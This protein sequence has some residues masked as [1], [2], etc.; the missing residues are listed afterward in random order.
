MALIQIHTTPLGPGLPNLVTLLF[1]RQV[2]G[3]MPV[4]DCKPI[5]QDHDG[6]HYG[7]LMDRQHTNDND[8]PPVFS[9]IP[10]GSAVVIQQEDGRL[11]THGMVVNKGN[12]NYHS[13]LYTI[14]L[15]TNGR[16][17]TQNR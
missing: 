2:Q 9:Y 1:N 6:N 8:T 4:L 5:R 12:H 14:Q 11:W 16:C 13:R 3:I 15:T 10:I 7:K 17:I